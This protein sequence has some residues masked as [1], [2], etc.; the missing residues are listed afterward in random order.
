MIRLCL[1]FLGG[2]LVLV[3]AGC[4]KSS[5]AVAEGKERN[6]ALYRKALEAERAGDIKD[7]IRQY[8]NLLIEE[9]RAFSVHLQLATL[10]QDYEENYIAALYHY[11]QYLILRPDSDKT[12][13]ARDRIRI[14]EQHLAPQILRKVGDSVEGITQAHLLKE[15][16]RLNRIIVQL[17]SDKSVL[18]EATERANRERATATNETV[19]LR[20]LLSR[21]RVAE[22]V[23]K[24]PATVPKKTDAASGTVSKPPVT[25]PP[26]PDNETKGAERLD[27]N[28]LKALRDEAAALATEGNRAATAER[29]TRTTTAEDVL[30]NAQQKVSGTDDTAAKPP[31]PPPKETPPDVLTNLLRGGE[32]T[33]TKTETTA[34]A[35]AEP[36]THVVQPGETLYGIAEKYYGSTTHWKKIRDANKT[37]IDPD[38]RVRAGQILVIPER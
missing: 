17:Q 37:R 36:R 30:R 35:S 32:R 34:T 16:D 10:L 1:S 8:R 5:V 19:R 28:A 38:W 22:T 6:S 15:N 18:I 26:K 14:S 25:L 31:T 24:P 20:E 29:T 9:P 2:V 4:G 21:M 11:Q 13:L 27:A 7:A 33:G 3:S 23:E 12:T